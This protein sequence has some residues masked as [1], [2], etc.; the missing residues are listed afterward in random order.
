MK[1][2][3]SATVVLAF[4]VLMAFHSATAAPADPGVSEFLSLV[5]PIGPEIENR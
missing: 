3:F 4:T 5:K 2:S 1:K